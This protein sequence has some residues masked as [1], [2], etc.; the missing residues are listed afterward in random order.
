MIRVLFLGTG[1]GR[2]NLI[3]QLRRTAGFCIQGPLNFYVD[4][5]PGSLAACKEF[6]LDPR[7][8]DAL[9]V[10]HNHI[11]HTNDAGLIAEAMSDYSR[12]RRGW[13]IGSESVIDGDENGD[14]GI[15]RYHQKKISHVRRAA[16]GKKIA[17]R[18]GSAR[19]TLTPFPVRHE[20]KTGFGFVLEM[21]GKRIGYTSDTEYYAGISRHYSGCDILIANN[22][23]AGDD[24]VPGHLHSATTARLLSEAKP[25]LAILTHMG[26]RLILASPSREA[27]RIGKLSGAKTI[28]AEDGMEIT[29]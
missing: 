14:K 26:R 19:A 8:M 12:K 25:K 21:G 15:T 10:S 22:L 16:H 2:F 4:P 17:I 29:L 5:G 9:V 20:D 23:K 24:G 27:K 18:K 3:S 13:L 7:S 28:P 6:S 1:G 11:D